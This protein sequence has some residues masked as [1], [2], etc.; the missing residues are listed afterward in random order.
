MANCIKLLIMSSDSVDGYKRMN[1]L[2]T[3]AWTGAEVYHR[4]IEELGHKIKFMQFEKD[5]L[6][7]DADWVEGIICNGLF[8]YHPIEQ[9][10]NLHFIQLTSAGFDRVNLAYIHDHNIV[11]HNAKGVYS[12]PMA[13]FAVA[14]VLAFYKRLNIFHDQQ[15]RRKWEKIRD[16]RELAGKRVAI[17]GCGETG[18]AC[19]KRFKAFECDIIGLNRTIHDIDWFD[20]VVDLGQID[21]ETEA[22][23]VVIVTIASTKETRGI[24]KARL[25]RPESVLVNIS[26]GEVVDLS[27]SRC[28]LILDVFEEEPLDESS[29]LWDEATITPHNSFVGEGNS[30]RLSAL[31]LRNLRNT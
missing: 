9:F 5:E 7:V 16:I 30:E 28:N 15:K 1:L 20:K 25:L 19:A 26:R 14:E 6:P 18:R 23:D 12:T 13:E 11:I 3:G 31:I 22:A 4:Q 2:I 27:D 21:K 29:G 24:V 17:I 10:K 8:V